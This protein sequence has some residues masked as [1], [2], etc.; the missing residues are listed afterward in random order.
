MRFWE[1]SWHMNH[2]SEQVLR[3]SHAVV[4]QEVCLTLSLAAHVAHQPHE[5]AWSQLQGGHLHA[6]APK[7]LA[8]F[9][10]LEHL[11]SDSLSGCCSGSL[12]SLFMNAAPQA[13]PLCVF[14]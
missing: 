2:A 14:H 4:R 5:G 11:T 10:S 6:H 1:Q 9:K 12:L 3:N 7:T 8:P 13:Q